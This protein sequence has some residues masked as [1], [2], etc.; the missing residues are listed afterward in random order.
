M[1]HEIFTVSEG[2]SRGISAQALRSRRLSAPTSG[3]RIDDPDPSLID[4]CRAIAR[5]VHPNAAFARTTA[6]RLLGVELPW[7]LEED[8]AIHVVTPRRGERPQRFAIRPHFCGQKK[9]DVVHRLGLRITSAPQTWLQV[10]HGLTRDSLVGL[11]DAMTRRKNPLTTVDELELLLRE[12]F[13]MRGL[14]LCREAVELVRS[15]TDSSMESRLR[16]IIIDAGLPEP[17]VNVPALDAT[18]QFLALPDLSYPE[19]KIA[20]EYDG[21]HHRTDPATWRRDVERRQL[22]E[23]A[24]W[25]IITATADDV[26]RYPDRL[27]RRIRAAI[28]ARKIQ[29]ER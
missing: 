23:G 29:Q 11:G 5:V 10:S 4:R 2:L 1:A 7:Q 18:G 13:K 9:L 16:L 12:T 8:H 19:L 24:G 28:R 6:L 17:L 22:L 14:A 15:G 21:D 27:I 20:V 25:L 3:V 26:I